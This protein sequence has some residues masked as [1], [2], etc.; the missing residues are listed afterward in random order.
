MSIFASDPPSLADS[1]PNKMARAQ[2]PRN[3]AATA[4]LSS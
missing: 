2:S 1:F 3:A 4:A